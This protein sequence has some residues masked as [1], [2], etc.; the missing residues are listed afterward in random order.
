MFG[1]CI[2]HILNTGCAKIWKKFRRQKVNPER[3]ADMVKLIWALKFYCKT[4]LNIYSTISPHE[5]FIYVLTSINN[6]AQSNIIME[7]IIK[8]I[9]SEQLVTPFWRN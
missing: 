5:H 3:Q 1:F 2:T 4:K 7:Q 6:T 8:F 9:L